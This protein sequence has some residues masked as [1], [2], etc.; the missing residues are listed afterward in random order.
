MNNKKNASLF[1]SFSR[2]SFTRKYPIIDLKDNIAKN[3][4]SNLKLEDSF[5][6]IKRGM[7]RNNFSYQIR[8]KEIFSHNNI[9]GISPFK[10]MR[11]HINVSNHL[12]L[13]SKESAI[14]N[15]NLYSHLLEFTKIQRPPQ[16]LI[17]LGYAFCA[18]FS[19]IFVNIFQT[20]VKLVF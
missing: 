20:T 19:W 10:Y 5:D 14:K 4:R 7:L 6:K 8:K 1:S 11:A 18:I 17:C 9:A 16:S 15:Y 13:Y 12:C 2:V 3:F